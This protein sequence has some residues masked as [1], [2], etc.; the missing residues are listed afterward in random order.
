[1]ESGTSFFERAGQLGA[2]FFS[3]FPVSQPRRKEKPVLLFYPP[4]SDLDELADAYFKARYFLL[5]ESISEVIFPV[6]FAMPFDLDEPELIH[7]PE[8]FADIPLPQPNPVRITHLSEMNINQELLRADFIFLW[9][10]KTRDAGFFVSSQVNKFKNIDRHSNTWDGWIWAPFCRSV[11]PREYH[12]QQR[13]DAKAQFNEYVASLPHYSKSYIFGTGPSLDTAYQY[14]FSDGYRIV[15]NT[16]V[17]NEAL[18]DHIQP[19]FIVAAD[20]IYHFGNTVHAYRFRC[21]L[22]RALVKR[23]LCFITQDNFYLLFMYYHP[24]AARST[25]PVRTDLPGIHLDLTKELAYSNIPNI[26]NG[27]LL[28]LGS[29]LA[30]EIYMLGFDGRAPADT[31]FWANSSLNSYSELK[32]T[33][34]AAHP[35]FFEGIDYQ[36]YAKE[37][38]D[39]AEKIMSLGESQGK[40]Y[41]CLNQTH[42]PALQKRQRN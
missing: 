40:R 39:N 16:I 4:F 33:I 19:H 12:L 9:D 20:A 3:H 35:A 31:Y 21:D 30:D 8:Y 5:P 38:S 18:L 42:I 36:D 11:Q 14:D 41:I 24:A 28:P 22:E 6:D 10:W 25:V 26:L 23:K 34:M 37:Q 7:K 13:A 17:K 29:T 1:M 2:K 15:C 32:P 27:L